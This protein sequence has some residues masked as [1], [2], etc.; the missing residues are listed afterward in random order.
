M[1]SD[2]VYICIQCK[3]A[4]DH[5]LGGENIVIVSPIVPIKGE[6]VLLT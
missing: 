5:V 3:N 6:S 2:D 1:L 4:Y